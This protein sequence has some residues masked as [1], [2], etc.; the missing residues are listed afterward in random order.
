MVNA[1]GRILVVDDEPELCLLY[2]C[3]LTDEGY[4]V[5]TATSG[6]G[7]LQLMDAFRPDLIVMDIRMPDMDG[8]E[9]MG[10][11]LNRRNDLPIVLNTAYCSYKDNFCTWVASAYIVKS[12]DPREMIATIRRL[13]APAETH[14]SSSQAA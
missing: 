11:M 8:I 14:H 4:E 10:R 6:A 12:S 2:R 5:A 3:L 9:A 7:A 1:A 13:L